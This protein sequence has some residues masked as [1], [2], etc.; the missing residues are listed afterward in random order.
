MICELRVKLIMERKH[1]RKNLN[2]QDVIA[3]Q[4]KDLKPKYAEEAPSVCVRACLH[5][6]CVCQ[7]MYKQ[8]IAARKAEGRWYRDK[9]FPDNEDVSRLQSVWHM[10]CMVFAACE[11]AF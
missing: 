8:V 5:V 3:I 1:E 4:G 9:D 6:V 2:R 11:L 7:A 10:G